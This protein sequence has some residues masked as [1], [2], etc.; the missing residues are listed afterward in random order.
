M[1]GISTD[2]LSPFLQEEDDED[3][4]N[5]HIPDNVELKEANEDLRPK[6]AMIQGDPS[7][8]DH[9]NVRDQFPMC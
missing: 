4:K 5:S 3:T 1:L 8:P 9:Y 2:L 6:K 7:L